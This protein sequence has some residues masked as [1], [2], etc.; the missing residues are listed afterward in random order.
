MS[1]QRYDGIVQSTAGAVLAGTSV[2]V[3]IKSTAAAAVIYSDEVLTVKTNPITTAADGSFWFY[4]ADDDYILVATHGAA[5]YT[6][7]DVTLHSPESWRQHVVKVASIPVNNSI[8]FKD[9]EELVFNVLTGETWEFT[10]V[11]SISTLPAADFRFQF[12]TT[13]GVSG[14][15][16]IAYVAYENVTL[17]EANHSIITWVRNIAYAG[18]ATAEPILIH[19]YIIATANATVNLTWAQRVADL[20]D[21]HVNIGSS[22]IARKVL[23]A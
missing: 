14:S 21:T 22:L 6:L 9:D 8:I 23:L 5:T 4:A 1:M 11:L 17:V 12:A 2:Q 19:G 18:V 20:S 13:P 3:N 7:G 15:G 16:Y 10:Y